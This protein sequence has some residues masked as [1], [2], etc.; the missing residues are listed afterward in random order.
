MPHP[1]CFSELLIITLPRR[2]GQL[3]I[4]LFG[5]TNHVQIYLL[6]SLSGYGVS[7]IR[8]GVRQADG[9]Q[10]KHLCYATSCYCLTTTLPISSG[11]SNLHY[12]QYMVTN[13]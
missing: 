11:A 12:L 2:N 5:I 1:S 8:T 7:G 13:R 6:G 3:H 10:D 4:L 9:H